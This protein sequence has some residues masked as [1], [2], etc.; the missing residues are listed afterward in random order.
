MPRVTRTSLSLRAN[1]PPTALAASTFSSTTE[2]QWKHLLPLWDSTD[3]VYINASSAA[4]LSARPDFSDGWLN[5][6]FGLGGSTVLLLCEFAPFSIELDILSDYILCPHLFSVKMRFPSFCCTIPTTFGAKPHARAI[7][8]DI[9]GEALTMLFTH[10]A[11][12]F[13]IAI[14]MNLVLS[15]LVPCAYCNGILMAYHVPTHLFPSWQSF[16]LRT[17]RVSLQINGE[18]IIC[19]VCSHLWI[20]GHKGKV[21]LLEC[22]LNSFFIVFATLVIQGAL[23]VLLFRDTATTTL[24]SSDRGRRTFGPPFRSA[25][26]MISCL[27]I[28]Q[29]VIQLLLNCSQSCWAISNETLF[30]KFSIVRTEIAPKASHIYPLLN[31]VSN[32]VLFYRLLHQRNLVIQLRGIS[33]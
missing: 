20:S 23:G 6:V 14:G 24:T 7:I 2:A 16:P 11:H 3:L 5:H 26:R 18:Q 21:P 30:S 29:P 31:T 33:D 28:Q 9:L 27:P 32:S 1:R 12:G 17:S 15:K 10:I 8:T 25:N 13:G 22:S 4:V 19:T